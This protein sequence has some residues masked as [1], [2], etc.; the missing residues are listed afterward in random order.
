[1]LQVQLYSLTGYPPQDL[2]V[3]SIFMM[4]DGLIG[5]VPVN[6]YETLLMNIMK[7]P[8]QVGNKMLTPKDGE[9][10]IRGLYLEYKSWALRATEAS[11]V[12]WPPNRGT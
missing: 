10:W 11:S 9:E 6:G 8:I 2:M 3:G 5:G 4:D 12:A 7:D 1:M